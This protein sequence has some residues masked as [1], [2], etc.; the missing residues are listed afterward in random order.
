MVRQSI[1]LVRE[2]QSG[3]AR[4]FRQIYRLEP[5]DDGSSR[6]YVLCQWVPRGA[7][8]PLAVRI[9]M[10][11]F[12]RRFRR[13]VEGLGREL[14]AA[15]ADPAAA[16]PERLLR[17][18]GRLAP[19][20]RHRVDA[21]RGELLA[22]GVDPAAL[23]RLIELAV[24][25]DDLELDPIRLG[26]LAS[27]G[28]VDRRALLVAAL[29]ATR[30]GL[31]ELSWDVVCPHCRGVGAK[32]AHLGDVPDAARCDAC[33]VEFGTDR[34]HAVEVAFRVHRSIRDVPETAF[35]TALPSRQQHIHVQQS[36]APGE[37]RTVVTDSRRAAT[38]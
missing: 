28:A 24:D 18:P 4:L 15:G 11:W 13:V 36:L 27:D 3:L 10:S 34:E 35:C 2:Y 38:G 1:E 37:E 8:G 33:A 30:A 32:L 12:E 14:A 17:Q 25:G 20:R 21:L 6:L 5:H 9:G 19:E 29:H 26:R 22:R 16:V 31:L 7:L 23:D